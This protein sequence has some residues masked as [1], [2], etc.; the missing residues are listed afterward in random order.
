MNKIKREEREGLH[1]FS[2]TTNLYASIVFYLPIKQMIPLSF[3][4]TK[5]V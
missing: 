3:C 1:T 5:V 2:D 4:C